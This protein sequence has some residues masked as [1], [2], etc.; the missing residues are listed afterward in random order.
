MIFV[1]VCEGRG[2]RRLTNLLGSEG[3]LLALLAHFGHVLLGFLGGLPGRFF[4]S[5][6]PCL[7][8]SHARAGSQAWLPIDVEM[9]SMI[10][11]VHHP[12]VCNS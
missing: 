6:D 4:L 5:P 8:F 2:T 9:H 1:F 10:Q 7:L 3:E 12:C 11:V